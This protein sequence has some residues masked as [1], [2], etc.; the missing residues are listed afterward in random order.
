MSLAERIN[1]FFDSY[2]PYGYD[3]AGWSTG[4]DNMRIHAESWIKVE[5]DKESADKINEAIQTLNI[6]KDEIGKISG[7]T[8]WWFK[9][10]DATDV[11]NR[12]LNGE[13]Y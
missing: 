8:D 2:A 4:G 11:L 13:M 10:D 6:I 7:G 12:I 5:L 3:D 9:L 1:K